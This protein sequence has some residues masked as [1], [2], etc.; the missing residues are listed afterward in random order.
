MFLRNRGIP[1][2]EK[3]I[4]T[5][6]DASKLREATGKEHLP[7]ILIGRTSQTGFEA[8][9]WGQALTA[10]GYPEAN[11]LPKSYQYSKAQPI[12]PAVSSSALASEPSVKPSNSVNTPGG[13]APPG[14]R[15]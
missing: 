15:F 6:E 2:S 4:N 1:F 12:T 9:T 5:A 11:K 3:T 13:N 7:A 10:A 14:F 8:G